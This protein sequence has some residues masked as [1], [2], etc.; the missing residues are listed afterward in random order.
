MRKQLSYSVGYCGIICYFLCQGHFS[1]C[2][3]LWHYSD[4]I[5]ST[6]AFQMTGVLIVWPIVCSG[7]YQRKHQSSASMAFVRGFH[8]WPV[9][10]PHK[11]PS[12]TGNVSIWW[13]HNESRSYLTGACVS[14]QLSC[15][16]S[17]Q[18]WASYL[19]VNSVSIFLKKKQ[20]WKTLHEPMTAKLND[21]YMHH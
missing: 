5:M 17:Y 4:V 18:M 13:R 12:N 20:S 19:K 14:M 21:V 15:A 3:I 11:G 10:S 2:S 6:I 8:R 1:F 9:D 16:D 7:T